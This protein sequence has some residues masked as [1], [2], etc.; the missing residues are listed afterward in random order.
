MKTTFNTLLFLVLIISGTSCSS[1]EEKNLPENFDYGTVGKGTYKNNF[2]NFDLSFNSHWF[3][4][5][6]DQMNNLVKAGNELV[7]GDD[8]DLKSAVEA[9]KVNTAYLLAIFKHEIGSA[10]EFNPSFM[11]MAENTKNSPGIK[12]GKDYLFHAKKGLQQSKVDYSFNK[13]VYPTEIGDKT[14]YV[15]EGE[16]HFMGNNIMQEYYATVTKGFSLSFIVTYTTQ[17]E[18]DEL[19]DILNSINI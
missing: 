19:Y 4:Q 8:N 18:K 13:E 6:E 12:T 3:V 16:M 14:F 2:F 17:E 15:L 5:D 11:A 9:S 1:S 7:I 10:V